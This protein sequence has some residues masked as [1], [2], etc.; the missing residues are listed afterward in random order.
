MTFMETFLV[1]QNAPPRWFFL[2]NKIPKPRLITRPNEKILFQPWPRP[3]LRLCLESNSFHTFTPFLTYWE[4]LVRLQHSGIIIALDTGTI[5]LYKRVWVAPF[6]CEW[7]CFSRPPFPFWIRAS[8]F[9]YPRF[10]ASSR[11]NFFLMCGEG[12]PALWSMTPFL[13]LQVQYL[14]YL[15]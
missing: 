2:P 1:G 12:A 7:Y 3:P 13:V 6:E 9:C 10:S 4:G 11:Q 5:M 14:Q 8:F 15:I